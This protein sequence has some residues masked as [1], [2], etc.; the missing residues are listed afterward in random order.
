LHQTGRRGAVNNTHGSA[1]PIPPGNNLLLGLLSADDLSGLTPHLEYLELPVP[2][3]LHQQSS[4]T[5]FAYFLNSGIA[6]VVSQFTDGGSVETGIAGQEG[7]WGSSLL[8]GVDSP[9]GRCFMQIGGDG[10]RVPKDIF[11]E[12][13]RRSRAFEDLLH[14]AAYLELIQSRQ[15][16][17][18]NARHEVV[19]RL[20]RWLL[21]CDDRVQGDG[22]ALTHEFLALMLGTRR[23]SVTLA[24]GSLQEAGIIRYTRRTIHIIHRVELEEAAC[25]CYG[26]IANE[27]E[28]VIG[29]T[30]H[31]LPEAS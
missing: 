14:R 29:L 28:R 5:Q 27:Y 23:S 18:C 30:P 7:L 24:A 15:L 3:V 2:F 20:A 11:V 13:V 1:V 31:R 6:S 16:A 22:L 8:A 19:E 9:P 21:M 4:P 10:F 26:V 12:S 17:A 25:Q